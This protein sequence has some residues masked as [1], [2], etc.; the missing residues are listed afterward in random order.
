MLP[1]IS[2][3]IKHATGSKYIDTIAICSDS[4][5]ILKYAKPP[6]RAIKLPEYIANG[7][8]EINK[9]IKHPTA[10]RKHQARPPF[11]PSQLMSGKQLPTKS[12]N[13]KKMM[14]G[15]VSNQAIA[16]SPCCF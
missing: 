5:H 16:L 4:D 15:T 3:A 10:I 13:V 2:W 6:I 14:K 11:P 9:L 12:R 7:T 1:L 8:S